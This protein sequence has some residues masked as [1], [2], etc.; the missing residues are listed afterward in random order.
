MPD[1]ATQV[2]KIPKKKQHQ[3][4]AS[5]SCSQAQF[6]PD[7]NNMGESSSLP[8]LPPFT[9][10]HYIMAGAMQQHRLS[11][12]SGQTPLQA[13]IQAQV[14]LVSSLMP[15]RRVSATGSAC[16]DS[17]SLEGCN[18]NDVL[19]GTFGRVWHLLDESH[20]D[21]LIR[22]NPLPC[23]AGGIG[24]AANFADLEPLPFSTELTVAEKWGDR[25]THP[26]SSS[27]FIPQQ[28]FS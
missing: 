15:S 24:N 25:D 20:D 14:E 26:F 17:T 3:V 28:Q 9:G 21:D 5:S 2:Q 16:T 23:S 7:P 11:V 22:S 8:S 18:S 13:Q 6:L 4:T 1:L 12:G 27:L 19:G 10:R